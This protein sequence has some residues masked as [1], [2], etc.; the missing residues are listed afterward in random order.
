MSTRREDVQKVLRGFPPEFLEPD[1]ALVIAEELARMLGETIA[2][3]VAEK[4]PKPKEIVTRT[5]D[6]KDEVVNR[7]YDVIKAEVPGKLTEIVIRSPTKDFS[8]LIV[9]DGVAKLSRTYD[10]L[11]ALSPHSEFLD[12]YE[13]AE[14]GVYL[15]HIKEMH[16]VSNFLATVYVDGSVTFHNIFAVWEEHL[17]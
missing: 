11:A 5:L 17:A 13:E 16:W 6:R 4:L 3:E 8:V 1:E 14:N 12:A 9:A 15:V 7:T 2:E 10:E